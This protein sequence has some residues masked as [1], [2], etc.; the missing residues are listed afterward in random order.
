MNALKEHDLKHWGILKADREKKY[1]DIRQQRK[2]AFQNQLEEKRDQVN[3]KLHKN[4][5][6]IGHL[7]I[8][9]KEICEEKKEEHRIKENTVKWQ[10]Q[11]QERI[12]DY[13]K[14]LQE[15]KIMEKQV[16]TEHFVQAK[17]EMMRERANLSIQSQLSKEIMKSTL[18]EMAMTKHWDPSRF[19]SPPSDR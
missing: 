10:R 3:K 13:H 8:K 18:L 7:R 2:Q 5:Q 12:S 19:S 15:A 14:L 16:K 6:K 1:A 9:Q 17:E 4:N 11:R